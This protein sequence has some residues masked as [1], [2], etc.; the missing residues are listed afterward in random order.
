[1]HVLPDIAFAPHTLREA[2]RQALDLSRDGQNYIVFCE[3]NLFVNIWRNP[4]VAAAVRAAGAV[5]ADGVSV[6]VYARLRGQRVP[7]RVAGPMMLPALCEAGLPLGLRHFF[8]GGREG[9]AD[10]LADRLRARYPGLVVAGA[11]S[12]PFRTFTPEDDAEIRRRV[13]AARPDVVWV[14]LGAPRQ[15]LWMA[16]Q[17]GRLDAPL[18]L[19]VGA[20]F[21][22]HA[23]T[24]PWAPLWVRRLGLEWAFRMLTGGP[25]VLLRN[26][27]CV[28]L[29]LAAL[30]LAAPG[31]L[32]RRLAGG[33]SP[34]AP[35]A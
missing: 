11:F 1:M 17:R 7:K 3:A 34:A 19:G 10:T 27:R 9:V 28:T 29:M 32:R 4:D 13:A 16:A 20:A 12:P 2:V 5:F 15:E 35:D 26:L 14:S 31:A 6:L 8:L 23:G 25:R 30:V 22:F 24:R 21:D 18:M 33:A